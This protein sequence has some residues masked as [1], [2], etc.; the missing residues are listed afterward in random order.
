MRYRAAARAAVTATLRVA[1]T[2]IDADHRFLALGIA[3][4]F[5]Q[6]IIRIGDRGIV[7]DLE[8]PF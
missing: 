5:A 7:D 3:F 8:R 4:A 2:A 1:I 6:A